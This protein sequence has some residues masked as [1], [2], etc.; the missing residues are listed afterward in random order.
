MRISDWSSDVCSSDLVG[1]D[2]QIDVVALFIVEQVLEAASGHEDS[3]AQAADDILCRLGPPDARERQVP[4][5]ILRD[6]AFATRHLERGGVLEAQKVEVGADR[7]LGRKAEVGGR[8]AKE[9]AQMG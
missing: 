8:A 5:D 3:G 2:R 7:P 4:A 6:R 1:E 9:G